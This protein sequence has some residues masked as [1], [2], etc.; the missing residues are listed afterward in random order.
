MGGRGSGRRHQGGA[1]TTEDI[2]ALDIRWLHRTQDICDPI[3]R[4]VTW[5]RC[6]GVHTTVAIEKTTSGLLFSYAFRAY[7]QEPVQVECVVSLLWSDTGFGGRRPWFCCPRCKRR[8]AIVYIS[9]TVAC[10]KCLGLGYQSQNECASDR[11]IRRIDFLRDKLKWEPG[12]LNGSEWRPKGM[13]YKTYERY[14]REYQWLTGYVNL[15]IAHRFG[16]AARVLGL[17]EHGR[18]K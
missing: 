11:A 2:S 12:F 1:A 18:K 16:F 14:L 7:G 3:R 15:S 10:R 9:R 6:G 4:T 17:N 5:S 13:H 8:T